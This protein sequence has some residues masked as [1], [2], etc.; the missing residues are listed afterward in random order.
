VKLYYAPASPYVRKVMILLHETGLE[1]KVERL[2]STT[3][4]MKSDT[5]LRKSNPL[6]KLPALILDS[7]ETLY[8]SRVICEYLDTTYA[9]G[10]FFPA[11]STLR[12]PALRRQ[13]LADGLLDAGL[14]VRYET[15]M[16]P[17]EKLWEEW[18]SGQ[19]AKVTEAATEME[20]EAPKFGDTFDIG[21]IAIACA[22][23]YLDFRYPEF[24]WRDDS[25]ALAAWFADFS[26]RPSLQKTVPTL[27]PAAR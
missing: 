1:P 25:P 13:S 2:S 5:A 11:D 22:L 15:K 21:T 12:W 3:T 16:R 9:G 20:R 23:G 18:R 24:D 8:D 6:T 26:K 10:R 19:W 7:G 14:I 17:P 4:P 27:Q